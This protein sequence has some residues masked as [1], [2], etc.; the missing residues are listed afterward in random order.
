MRS[1]KGWDGQLVT[2]FA[3]GSML[4]A[5]EYMARTGVTGVDAR[6]SGRGVGCMACGWVLAVEGFLLPSG[7]RHL[8]Q[9][10]LMQGCSNAVPSTPKFPPGQDGEKRQPWNSASK[11]PP[12]RP[13]DFA[14]NLVRQQGRPTWPRRGAAWVCCQWMSIFAFF[15]RAS[16]LAGKVPLGMPGISVVSTW[17]SLPAG[18]A[19][20]GI[21]EK[22]VPCSPFRL[23][24]LI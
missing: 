7:S 1:C 21:V 17:L 6:G 12:M 24:T 23:P 22:K 16:R 3:S 9:M 4:G 2:G 13:I 10:V 18:W 19:A 20:V 5:E 11:V 14:L 15:F 8:L